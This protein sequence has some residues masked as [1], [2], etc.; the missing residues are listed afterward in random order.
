MTDRYDVAEVEE[1]WQAYWA[2]HGTYEVEEGG[3]RPKF[4][5]LCMYP[6]PSGPIHMGHVRNYTLGDVICRYKTMQGYNV[7]SPMGWDS[8]GLPAENAAIKE[9]GHPALI[10][11]ERIDVMRQQIKRLGSVYDWRREVS[12]FDPAYYRWTQYLFL[13]LYGAG[14]AY[15]NNAMVNWCPSCKTTLA[16]EQAE[17]GE[18]ERCGTPVVRRALEQWF[19][20]ITDYAQELLDDLEALD[21][22]E[23]VKT[24]Q[25]NWIGRSEGVE[26]DLE[27]AP[28]AGAAT[29]SDK[30]RVFTTRIDTVF[31]MTYAVMAPEHPKVAELIGG[32]ENEAEIQAF[33]DRVT[34]ES[35]MDRL[36]SDGA[37]DKRGIFTGR[38]VI[39]P[40]TGEPVPLYL[41]DY[42]LATYGTGAI[43]AVPGEDDRDFQF[44]QVH[45][46]PVIE[47]TERP[48]GWA[49]ATYA[50][51]GMKINSSWLD[52]SDVHSAKTAATQWL[53]EQG[54]GEAKVNYRLRDWL[55]SRQRYWGCP[56][57][58]IY[59]DG[60]GVVPVPVD[61]LPVKLPDEVEFTPTGESPLKSHPDFAQVSC[62]RC[63]GDARRETDT[64]DTFVDSSWYFLRYCDPHNTELPFDAAK[65]ASWMPVDQYIGGI[66]HA[67]LHL[68]YARFFT[69]A[70][71]DLG[72]IDGSL[73][74]PFASLFTQGMIRLGGTKMS[75]SK[76][77]LVS[78]ASFF[79][80]HGA[81]AL[82]LFHLFIGPPTD[83]VDWNDNGVDGASRY[84]ARVWR[85]ANG[86]V[87]TI[88]SR[89][90][91]T[92]ADRE[93]VR[94]RH[95]LVADVSEEYERW[96]YNTAV[97]RLMEYTNELYKVA[98][99]ADGIAE[100]ALAEGLDA[101]LLLLA[102]MCPHVTAELWERR[103]ESH[104]HAQPWP[105]YDP[106]A[107][108]RQV[109]TLVVQI[110]GKVRETM[111]VPSDLSAEALQAAAEASPKVQGYLEAGTVRKVIV[112]PPNVVNFVVA[113]G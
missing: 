81:D 112:R 68:M 69:K 106:E 74:E 4:Y 77:N 102:P 22:P 18:C 21:W 11:S 6:Y 58:I 101:L 54:S 73:R 10:T 90:D 88:V 67:I 60:C 19:F 42:V 107:A 5:D 12:S 41:A 46:L 24:M 3:S 91:Y 27:V 83:G 52:G 75:K 8:F 98:Q 30:I 80:S 103:Y 28:L 33:I 110:N 66:E 20:R 53:A 84:L 23:R 26:F 55:V 25:R 44:A 15:R 61:Q 16:N 64:M 79:E 99:S 45:G 92:A 86:E 56:I 9:G 95:Q 100:S 97:A 17:T 50:G 89:D 1:K 13:Q 111:E 87:G 47:T 108:K 39:N 62:P 34:N 51:P 93:V 63:G 57:P 76:G 38:Q 59:C 113:N 35:E 32:V 31:G 85:L 2:T 72:L 37:L 94:L 29:A 82:R 49:E 78:P 105:A 43:M 36:S 104:I 14:L 96:S 70:F 71:A 109:V 65:V 48:D 7:L 40:F